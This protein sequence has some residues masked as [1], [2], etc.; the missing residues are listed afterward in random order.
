MTVI[1]SEVLSWQV[2]S[3]PPAHGGQVS[4]VTAREA[5]LGNS[6]VQLC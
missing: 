6:Q 3:L 4:N 5:K 2:H 1:P